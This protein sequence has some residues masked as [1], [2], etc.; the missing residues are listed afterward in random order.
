MRFSNCLKKCTLLYLGV[1]SFLTDDDYLS[2]KCQ[3]VYSTSQYLLGE[4][5]G[6]SRFV[7]I[8]EGLKATHSRFSFLYNTLEDR[9]YFQSKVVFFFK[10]LY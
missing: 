9:K 10:W 8:F 6:I 2:L 5:S 3:L 1:F 4:E 7:G